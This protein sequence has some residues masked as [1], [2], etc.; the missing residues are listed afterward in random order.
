MSSNDRI[1]FLAGGDNFEIT[2]EEIDRIPFRNM[3]SITNSVALEAGL[4]YDIT[5]STF[6]LKSTTNYQDLYVDFTKSGLRF[7]IPS[8]NMLIRVDQ[9]NLNLNRKIITR[10]N[11]S[12]NYVDF[13]GI[14]SNTYISLYSSKFIEYSTTSG[15]IRYLHCIPE[16]YYTN[17][18]YRIAIAPGNAAIPAGKLTI[19]FFQF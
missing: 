18:V 13:Y 9:S 4:N 5:P 3:I 16:D 1:L 11:I 19:D 2:G 8:K 7:K 10:F 14:W 15:I 6:T 12:C 17:M